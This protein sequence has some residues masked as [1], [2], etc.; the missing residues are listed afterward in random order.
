[1]KKALFS[2]IMSAVVVLAAVLTRVKVS[3]VEEPPRARSSKNGTYTR[4]NAS[5][6]KRLAQVAKAHGKGAR[7]TWWAVHES[8]GYF[9][10]S[11]TEKGDADKLTARWEDGGHTAVFSLNKVWKSTMLHVPRGHA[12]V[13]DVDVDDTSEVGAALRI[14]YEKARLEQVGQHPTAPQPQPPAGP[15]TKT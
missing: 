3:E 9:W 15:E 12:M 11:P 8:D 7:Y 2:L 13:M 10:L 4:L 6:T 14:H 1:M 5:A